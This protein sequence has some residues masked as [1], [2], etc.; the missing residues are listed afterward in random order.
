MNQKFKV[1]KNGNIEIT[2]INDIPDIIVALFNDI[3]IVSNPTT[4]GG[5]TTIANAIDET[6]SMTKDEAK[7]LSLVGGKIDYIRGVP[8]KIIFK[9]KTEIRVDLYDDEY[10]EG[11]AAEVIE[12]LFKQK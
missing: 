7:M 8:M 10:G 12:G 6:L 9:S 4:P 1:K 2:D 11:R 3:V 5:L